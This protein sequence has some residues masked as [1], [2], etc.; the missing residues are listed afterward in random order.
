[1]ICA[2]QSFSG[3]ERVSG[4]LD[5][6]CS[7][8]AGTEILL[9]GPTRECVDHLARQVSLKQRAT[10]GLHRFSLTQLAVRLAAV[11]F[12]RGGQAASTALGTEALAARAIFEAKERK[13]L[14]FFRAVADRP[15]LVRAVAST[16]AEIR[17]ANI[18]PSVLTELREPGPDV[19]ALLLLFEQEL[20]AASVADRAT[21]FR[22]A[23]QS[24]E[25]GGEALKRLP[26]VLLDPPINSSVE[27]DFI[28]ALVR[29]SPAVF[30]TLADGDSKAL[31]AVMTLPG[32]NL[33]QSPR[34][35]D[36]S[37][38]ARL[39]RYLFSE[40]K[41]PRSEPGKE[42]RLFSA[43]GEGRECVEIARRVLGEARQGVRFDQMAILVRAPGTYSSLLERAKPRWHSRL[44]QSGYE[45]TRPIGSSVSLHSRL[46]C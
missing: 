30:L 28:A 19:A 34:K 24:L 7:Y 33:K 31:S 22:T 38:L 43:P 32:V 15:G 46:R 27:R 8:P 6:V 12:A 36:V 23:S 40:E 37:P 20:M 26:M 3:S 13:A 25:Q 10:F 42:V 5:F 2:L 9:V 45:K 1:M 11:D 18:D 14:H 44:F 17:A 39:G 4:S 35:S 16:L 21:L 29:D 41:P